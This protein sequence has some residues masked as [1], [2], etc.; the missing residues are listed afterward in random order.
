MLHHERFVDRVVVG[1]RFFGA[2]IQRDNKEKF[3]SLPE[4]VLRRVEECAYPT[5]SRLGYRPLLATGFRAASR[6]DMITGRAHDA[7]AM[8]LVGNRYSDNNSLYWRCWQIAAMIRSR[9][10]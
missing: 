9:F 5:M 6:W 2:P 1:K 4:R 8:V 3:R 10:V 7:A